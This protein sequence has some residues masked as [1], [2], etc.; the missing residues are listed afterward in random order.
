MVI[1]LIDALIKEGI[2]TINKEFI[3]PKIKEWSMN[4]KV[5]NCLINSDNVLNKYEEE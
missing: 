1:I 5:D 2:S 4:N 3:I